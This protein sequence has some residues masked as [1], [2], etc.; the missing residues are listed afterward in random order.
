MNHIER[1]TKAGKELLTMDNS[2]LLALLNDLE[3]D[4]VEHKASVTGH[5]DRICEAI[6]AFARALRRI[7][8]E[9]NQSSR[10]ASLFIRLDGDKT[11]RFLRCRAR[12]HCR[13]WR[14]WLL[15]G[16]Q[17][18]GWQSDQGI[19]V[20]RMVVFEG[21][22]TLERAGVDRDLRGIRPAGLVA[23]DHLVGRL[24]RGVLH[25]VRHIPGERDR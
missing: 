6:C 5:Q 21:L 23:Y 11:L 22:H 4:R 19:N 18:P 17:G 20:D 24:A 16:R 10:F 7:K 15:R 14:S 8:R 1:S 12:R 9:A 3:S 2:E 13:G 25:H